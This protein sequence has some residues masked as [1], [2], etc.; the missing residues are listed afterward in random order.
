MLHKTLNELEVDFK[1]NIIEAENSLEKTERL[2]EKTRK[3]LARILLRNELK[4]MDEHEVRIHLLE[5]VDLIQ[6]SMDITI[7]VIYDL[8]WIRGAV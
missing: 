4:D 7:E 3:K 1:R 8:N 2:Q 5:A 6:E